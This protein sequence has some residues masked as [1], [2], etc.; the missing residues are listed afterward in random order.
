[1]VTLVVI[2]C[3]LV[4]S[5]LLIDLEILEVDKESSAPEVSRSPKKLKM[6]FLLVAMV[7]ITFHIAPFFLNE[8]C[9]FKTSSDFFQVIHYISIGILSIFMIEIAVKIFAFRLDFFKSKM[10]VF[11]AIIVVVSFVLDI[12]YASAEG[13]ESAVGLIIIL[14]LWRVT[15]ILNGKILLYMLCITHDSQ[16]W[17]MYH[18][19]P[20]KRNSLSTS[21]V[22]YRINIASCHLIKMWI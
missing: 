11:D 20:Y 8:S 2:D 13:V 16:E 12:V 4:I 10:E 14:R 1:M 7:E 9:R 3:I 5:E 18:I 17:Y 15:R 6:D 21:P 22:I 19:H